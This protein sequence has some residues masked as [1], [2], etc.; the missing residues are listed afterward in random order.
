MDGS[1]SSEVGDF[2][3]VPHGLG[4]IT[5]ILI[6]HRAPT[7]SGNGTFFQGKAAHEASSDERLSVL[8]VEFV[9]INDRADSVSAWPAVGH[10]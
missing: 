9:T 10:G 7:R 4:R 8:R 5:S 2:Y 1:R 3:R 6:S